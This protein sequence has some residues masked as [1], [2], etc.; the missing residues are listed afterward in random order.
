MLLLEEGGHSHKKSES[1]LEKIERISEQNLMACYQC[2]KCTA[3]CPF[4]LSPSLV[5]RTLQFGKIEEARELATTWECAACYT[6]KTVCPK[7]LSPVGAMKALRA[8]DPVRP[9]TSM[10]VIRPEKPVDGFNGERE[11]L[12]GWRASWARWL[13]RFRANMI[14]D[15]PGKLK[16]MQRLQP[17]STL[18]LKVPGLRLLLHVLFGLHQ[19]RPLPQLAKVSFPTWFES[20]KP[21]GNGK[22]GTVLLFHDTLMDVSYPQIGIAATELLELAGYEVELA[23][24]VCC[25]RPAIS[26]GLNEKASVC[27]KD[28]VSRLHAAAAEG[29]YIIGCEPSCLLSFRDEYPHLVPKD[30]EAKAKTVAKQAMLIDEFLSML[31]EKGELDLKFKAPEKKEVL[32]HGH[33]HQK[34]FASPDQT[35]AML[36]LA[37]YEPELINAACCG[38]AGA[39]G[40]EAEHYEASKAAG[41]RALFPALRENPDAQLVVMGVSCRQ[42]VDHFMGRPLKHFIEAMRDAVEEPAVKVDE[43]PKAAPKPVEEKPAAKKASSGDGE[44][45]A[46]APPKPKKTASKDSEA[47]A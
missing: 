19:E 5:V 33:C 46:K 17:L 36:E 18:L 47:R 45:E 23:D 32:F 9:I 25:G 27:A 42:Q 14:A 26:K 21:K 44:L 15:M 39:H 40:V 29:K 35:L 8:M 22:K 16:M 7:G 43:K 24:N 2:G 31:A 1:P 38:M 3:D 30:M 11:L 37:G 10:V 13:R 41:E 34:A 4:F 6:C 12:K 28:N 20:H